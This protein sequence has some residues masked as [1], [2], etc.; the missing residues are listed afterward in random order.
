MSRPA[1]RMQEA[2]RNE[3]FG[4][5]VREI[6]SLDPAIRWVALEEAGYPPRWVWHDPEEGQLRLG[7]GAHADELLDPLILVLAEGRDELYGAGD[8]SPSQPLRFVLLAYDGWVQIAARWRRDA[9]V[10]V[11]VASTA[12]AYRLGRKLASLLDGHRNGRVVAR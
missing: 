3:F 5:I 6:L 2:G 7:T 1:G 4:R 12:D 9:H 11:G 10:S 8:G